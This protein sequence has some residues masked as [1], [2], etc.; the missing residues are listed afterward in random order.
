MQAFGE[1]FGFERVVAFVRFGFGQEIEEQCRH[2]I[3]VQ[4]ARDVFVAWTDAAAVASMS[5]KNRTDGMLGNREYSPESMNPD[6]MPG[7]RRGVGS[8]HGKVPR[9]R[10][11]IS[12]SPVREHVGKPSRRLGQ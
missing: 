1:Q 5:K 10:D 8:V 2:P 4:P 6:A 11:R 3:F 7:F 9:C 12:N